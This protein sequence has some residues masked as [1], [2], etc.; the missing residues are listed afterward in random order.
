MKKLSEWTYECKMQFNIDLNKQAQGIIVNQRKLQKHLGLFLG[1][2]F[3]INHQ[4]KKTSQSHDRSQ[5][6]QEI[7]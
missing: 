6:Y 3:G 4:I 1:K 5:C 7:K 2:K